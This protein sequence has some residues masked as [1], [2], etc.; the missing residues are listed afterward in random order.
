MI[1]RFAT[2]TAASIAMPATPISWPRPC[3]FTA[4]G[5]SST[6]TTGLPGHQRERAAPEVEKER[7]ATSRNWSSLTR[8]PTV[9]DDTRVMHAEIGQYAV[10][11]R[12]S[13]ES[14]FVGA[15]NNSQQRTLKLSLDFL[16]PHQDYVAHIYVDDP[17][18]TTR[19]HVRIDHLSVTSESVLDL[20][21]ASQSGQA[22]WIAPR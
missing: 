12:Q 22:M 8:V 7:L 3:A 6:G 4:P 20:Q 13:G 2:T 19:T 1:I 21:L 5:S 10:I 17:T 18:V 15:M 14:W 16:E 11:A 9:W